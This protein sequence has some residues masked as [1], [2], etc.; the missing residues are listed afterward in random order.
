V[1]IQE[2]VDV[3]DDPVASDLD[4]MQRRFSLDSL[5]RHQERLKVQV[6]CKVAERTA[7]SPDQLKKKR[8]ELARIDRAIA[9]LRGQLAVWD[10]HD[11]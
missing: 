8:R 10:T 1:T 9:M 7:L 11:Q 5:E 4:A 2:T 3:P 6:F